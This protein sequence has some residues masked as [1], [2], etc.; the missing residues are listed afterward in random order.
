MNERI[1]IS[2]ARADGNDAANR[3]IKLLSTEGHPT[4]HDLRKLEPDRSVWSQIEDALKATEF[5]IVIVTPAALKS[6]YIRAEWREAR[7]QGLTVMPV[8]AMKQSRS[9]LPRWL[10][11]CEIYDLEAPVHC[12]KFLSRLNSSGRIFRADWDAGLKI[13]TFIARPKLFA[14][15]KALLLSE[16]AEPV[17]L[18]SA[19]QGRGGYGKSVLAGEIARDPEIRDAYI[20]GVFWVD[21]GQDNP[22]VLGKI[23]DLIRRISGANGAPDVNT[24]AE[25]LRRLLEKRDVLIILDDV[26]RRQD[27]YPFAKATGQG[28]A[29]L[30]A[31]TRKL[32][33]LPPSAQT[34]D[35][36]GMEP[37][38][39]VALLSYGLAPDDTEQQALSKFASDFWHWPQLL[40][41]ANGLLRGRL[42]DGDTLLH[43]LETIADGARRG[44]VPGKDERERTIANIMQMGIEDLEP[45][46]RERFR[47][48]AVVPE[49]TAIPVAI[50]A[51]LWKLTQ[52]EAEEFAR[53]LLDRRLIQS[54]DL[55]DPAVGARIRMHDD[56]LWYLGAI[57]DEVSKRDLHNAL[58]A[59]HRPESGNW[60][61]LDQEKP[62]LHYLWRHLLWHLEQAGEDETAN[63]L[64][65]DYGWIKA[66]L[67]LLGIDRLL[68]DYRPRPADRSAAWVGNAL[69]L[70]RNDLQQDRSQLGFQLYGRLNHLA[71]HEFDNIC[72]KTRRD[73]PFFDPV[74]LRLSSPGA[75]LTRMRGH[76]DSVESVAFSHYSDGNRI[77]S[78]SRDGTLRLWDAE[79]GAA[80]GEPLRG[81][82]GSVRSVAFSPDGSRIVSGGDD[83]TLRLW[84]A[85]TGAP[86]GKPLRAHEGGVNCVAFSPDG[87]RIVSGDFV[88]SGF[89][90][91]LRVW[92]ATTGAA[93]GE[94]LRVHKGGV[95]SVAFS[96]DSRRIVSGGDCGSLR[97]W[98]ADT[99]AP[100]GN[101]S[102][103]LE[104]AITSVA[105]SHDG[106][107]II[108]GS[109]DHT[110]RLW[111][112]DTCAALGEPLRGHM[113]WV[114]SVAFS[115][116]GLR[117]VSGDSGGT[118]CLWDADT[119][120]QLSE[121]LRGHENWI[122]SVAFSPDSRSIVSGGGDGILRL[123]DVDICAKLV[124]PLRR[125]EDSIRSVA[126]SPDGRRIVSGGRDGTLHFWDAETGATLGEPLRGH[127]G[128]VLSVAYSHDGDR[129]VS[130]GDHGKLCIW[131]VASGASLYEKLHLGSAYTVTCVAFSPDDSRI[132]S[133]CGGGTLFLWDAETCTQL[134]DPLNGHD[135][136]VTCVAFS[137][138]GGRIFSGGGHGTLRLWD[139]ETG[140]ALVKPLSGQEGIVD[141]IAFS[142][143]GR[144]IV[145][146]DS[147]GTLILRYADTGSPL[148]DPLLGHEGRVLNVAFSPD[149]SRIV[150]GDS[151]GMMGIWDVSACR[152]EASL[153]FDSSLNSIAQSES[154]IAIGDA[155]GN[156]HILRWKTPE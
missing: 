43:A 69:Q 88:S 114:N 134:G 27:L 155:L 97:L 120:A 148:S 24:G 110:L 132:I 50:L 124:E 128:R 62:A 77:V 19:L 51:P 150:S 79:T 154:H 112:A 136:E 42:R 30:L 75:E 82:R 60:A 101:P 21:L 70:S 146:G 46:D 14:Q 16:T 32:D 107:R 9:T 133:G 98:D 117:I 76:L 118:L 108:S 15:I 4:W 141:S 91:T 85:A 111:D 35:I 99:G 138:D 38:E 140:A 115:P 94:P 20:D 17:S 135:G 80:L 151:D 59:A 78:G 127:E 130:G 72:E 29:T 92:D 34:I 65:V 55:S 11:R 131:D 66:K 139:A 153:H 7:R 103:G 122:A 8:M 144:H 121:P 125:Y 53:L 18:T 3:L 116:D 54:R 68:T 84:D 74:S 56:M 49:D 36:S 26:W 83:R 13:E 40:A 145:S 37:D 109:R 123:W 12:E 100:L 89:D 5:L 47:A 58:L 61:D 41:I 6:D 73:I 2:Y 156:I 86:L 81:H 71:G 45:E 113:D 87:N 142:D 105:F 126:F 67:I 119:C 104:C 152:L 64:R 1:F 102:R 28:N 10:R 44:V 57:T 96:H 25:E 48:L 52:Y 93:L 137:P 95:N 129:I 33:A 22:D 149:D 143:S 106:R 23:N 31:T 90:S 39:A 63:A 147:D